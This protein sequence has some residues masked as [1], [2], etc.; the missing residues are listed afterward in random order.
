MSAEP[1]RPL[2]WKQVG[3]PPSTAAIRDMAIARLASRLA[4]VI[5]RVLGHPAPPPPEGKP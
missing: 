4:E 3:Q 1:S 5:E 2:D